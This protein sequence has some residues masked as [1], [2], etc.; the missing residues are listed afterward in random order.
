ML[1][2]MES[3]TAGRDLATEQHPVLLNEKENDLPSELPQLNL[4]QIFCYCMI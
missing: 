4:Y 1:Q 3:Q 2:S